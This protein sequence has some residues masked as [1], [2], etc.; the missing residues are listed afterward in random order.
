[1]QYKILIAERDKCYS[2]FSEDLI[3][4]P[5]ISWK[6]FVVY[7]HLGAFKAEDRC[8]DSGNIRGDIHGYCQRFSDTSYLACAPE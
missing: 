2:K 4:R 1:M 6:M 3:V 8:Y 7:L 5:E